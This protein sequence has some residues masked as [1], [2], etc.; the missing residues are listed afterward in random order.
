[1]CLP[2]TSA[3]V[4]RLFSAIN[5]ICSTEKTQL[6]IKTPKSML[7]VKYNMDYSCVQLYDVLNKNPATLRTIGSNEKYSSNATK[8]LVA[9]TS[10][11]K[12]IIYSYIS[13]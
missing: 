11:Q 12:Y 2:G 3:S 5:K 7:I 6:Q 9:S 4:E 1:M 10:S 13:E 8:E